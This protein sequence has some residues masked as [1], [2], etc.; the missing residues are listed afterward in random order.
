MNE[1]QREYLRHAVMEF[2]AARHPTA[3]PARAIRRRV[4]D[5][6]DFPLT[7]ADVTATAKFLEELGHVKTTV[8]PFGSTE[9]FAATSPGVLAWERRLKG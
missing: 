4:A 7:D 1:E 6:V 3:H 9:S 8:D 2:L 5:E